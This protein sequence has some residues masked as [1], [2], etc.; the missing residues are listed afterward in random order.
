MLY[1]KFMLLGNQSADLCHGI[2]PF[3]EYK[4]RK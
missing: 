4:G 1:Q 2:R 3:D